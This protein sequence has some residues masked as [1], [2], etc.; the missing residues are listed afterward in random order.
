MNAAKLVA[1][2]DKNRYSDILPCKFLSD[3]G[4]LYSQWIHCELGCFRKWLG[5]DLS[6]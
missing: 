2:E 4:F 1:N 5:G 6:Q 3:L